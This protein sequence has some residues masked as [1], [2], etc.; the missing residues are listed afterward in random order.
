[1]LGLQVLN[2]GIRVWFR[3]LSLPLHWQQQWSVVEIL[4]DLK[5]FYSQ[6]ACVS[7]RQVRRN[8]HLA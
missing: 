3:G 2:G 1:M 8:L 4:D 6:D 5:Y 7:L